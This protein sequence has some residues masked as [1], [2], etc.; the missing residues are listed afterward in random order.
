MTTFKAEVYAHQRKADGTFNIKI[1]V[2]HNRQKKYLAT[3]YYVDKDDLTRTYKIKNQYYLDKCDA[4]IKR[5]RKRCDEIGE[6]L[7][8]MDIDEVVTIISANNNMFDLDFIQYA[9][10]QIKAMID[11]GRGS[12][13]KT[14]ENAINNL[15]KFVGRDNI[16]IK[17]IT[18]GLLKNWVKWI[19][20][21]SSDKR[22]WA[23]NNYPNR[24][25]SLHNMA[26]KEYNDEDA[27]TIN[28]PNSPF[29]HFTLPSI[30]SVRKRAISIDLLSKI[31]ILPYKEVVN[32]GFNRYN[33]AKDMFLLS[34]M[35]IG[36]NEA[37]LYNC[38]DYKNGRITY[39]RTKTKNRRS[40]N[41]EISIKIEPEAKQL[42]EK[43]IDKSGKHVFCFSNHY[44]TV[45]AFCAAINK[46]L[47]LIG[48]EIGIDDLEYYAAR[49][50]WATIAINDAGIDKYT[51]HQALNH[52]DDSMR[53]TD[54]YIKK[55]WSNIDIANRKVLDLLK[56]DLQIK[57][58][59]YMRK[60]PKNTWKNTK[61]SNNT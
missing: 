33:L 28:I 13:A 42:I 50:T 47:K 20:E 61:K 48:N 51:V 30:P 36:I 24:I 10:S 11:S 22:G 41:A 34:F 44:A 39:Q 35:L 53:V 52:V 17:E 4:I 16:S 26:K 57:E 60:Y 8:Q 9:K 58:P 54:I 7:K 40:D 19:D 46:G 25:R 2:T 21:R 3:P 32:N 1:R 45:D 5:Y 23:K 56:F 55:S 59:I 14:Y 27:G 12:T 38:T 43:Y 49:H 6:S 37:D 31:S 29:A 15:I 18:V